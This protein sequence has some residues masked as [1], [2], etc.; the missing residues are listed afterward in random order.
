[1]I[2][3]RGSRDRWYLD[4]ARFSTRIPLAEII[5]RLIKL[6]MASLKQPPV[7]NPDGG[8]NYADWKNDLEVWC[9]LT[10]G[11][12]KQ[13]PAVFL[14]L[15][16]DARDAVRPIP[17]EKLNDKD[18]V[19]QILAELDKVYLKDEVSRAFTAIKTFVQFRRESTQPFAKFLVDFNNKYREVKKHKLD[20]DDGILAFFLLMAANLTE[21]HERLVRATAELKFEDVKDKLQKV[22]G[23][24]DGK[25]GEMHDSKL[26]VKEDC[27]Y[28]RNFNRNG[29]SQSGA[30]S[31]YSQSNQRG[32]F[33]RGTTGRGSF[34]T[35]RGSFSRGAGRT[36]GN[37]KDPQGAVMRCF[38]CEST[39]HMIKDCPHKVKTTEHA[40]YMVQ[41]TFVAGVASREQDV[42]LHE[43]LAR[44]IID[45]GCTKTVAGKAWVDE[46][47]TM[48]NKEDRERVEKSAKK[49][50]TMYRF[51]DG[52][53]TKSIKELAIPMFICGKKIVLAVEVV[54]SNIPLL[55]GRP[56]MT[57]L[58]MI[59]DTV[60]HSVKVDEKTFRLG[61]SSSGHYILPV[62]EFTFE[63]TEFVLKMENLSTYSKAVKKEKAK[64]LHR[65]FAH[66]SKERLFRLL[67]DGGCQDT[68]FFKILEKCCN[69]CKFCQ[70]Y[71]H[72]KP[73]PIVG[74]PKGDRFNQTV[75]MDLKEIHKG[76]LWILHL[77]DN[78]T[79]YT[80]AT[81]I[82]SKRKEVIVKKIFQIWLSYFGSP[83]T[84]HSDCGGEFDNEVFREMS[85]TF[86]VKISTTPG[87]SP[88]SNGI[89][90]RGNTMLY[91]TMMKT[92]EDSKCSMETALAWAV[93]AKNCLQNVNGYSPN[94]LVLGRNVN[95][96]SV[97]HDKL[98][99]LENPTSSDLVR[100]NL[101]TMHKARENFIKS[102]ASERI[103]RALKHNVRTYSEVVF[104]PGEEVYYRGR[105][106]KR[107]K[108]PAKVLGKES[109]FVLIRNGAT[110]YRCH[111]C[112]LIKASNEKVEMSCPQPIEKS[113]TQNLDSSQKQ[114][115]VENESNGSE[116]D[117]DEEEHIDGNQKPIEVENES[118]E[119]EADIDEE[120][121]EINEEKNLSSSPQL[122]EVENEEEDIEINESE[123]LDSSQHCVEVENEEEE[124]ET[125][126]RENPEVSSKSN[127]EPRALRNL[128]NYNKPGVK[129]HGVEFL[130]NS[131]MMP[132]LRTTVQYALPD[133]TVTGAHVLS[134]RTKDK[135]KQVKQV[136]VQVIG[137]ENPSVVDWERVVWWREVGKT[138]QVFTLT[139]IEECE[140]DVVEAKEREVQ[141][142]IE[143]DVFEVVDDKG[144]T[145]VSCRW[146]YQEKQKADGSKLLKAR[147][148]AR[149]FEE[150][151]V[152]KKVDSPTCSRQSLRLALISATAMDW[153]LHVLDISSAFLQG[154]KLKRTVYVKPPP[155]VCEPEKIWRLK[156]CLYG[157]ADAPREWY[158]RVCEEMKKMG[159]TVSIY[160]KSVFMW[161]EDSKLVGLIIT[162][163]D[164][165][166]YCGTLKWQRK[167][168]D[169]LAKTFKISKKEKGC[170]KYIGLNIEQDK[171]QIFIDQAAYVNDLK[172]IS[173]T[174]TR[175]QQVDDSL[176]EEE[177]KKLRSVC[178]QVLWVTSQTRPD[179]AF[180]G[181]II[182]N[183][184]N[185]PKVK[186]LLEANKTVKKLKSDQLKIVYPNLG[187]PTEM[188]VVIY[189]DGSHASLMSGASQGGNI[190]FLTGEG[191]A[192]PVTWK[193]K[194]LDRVTKSPLAT[195]I[196][197][198]AD[199]ADNG[200]LVAAM[201]KE[202]F[203]LQSLPEI[204]LHTDSF[205][206]KE[207]LDSKK[208]I[209]DPRLRVDIARLR[210]M[211][212]MKEVKFKWVP[213]GQQLA[214]CL[215]KK[216]ASTDLLRSVLATGVLPE[217]R[218]SQM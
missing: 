6:E 148:V 129:E 214:D 27:M 159:A 74:F 151:L 44:A 217:H 69:D 95:L 98:P 10:D 169:S 46:F 200:Y 120:N 140:K 209:S 178:G 193:S 76:K 147:L 45:C 14:S 36:R 199:A 172:E 113:G 155:E 184:G 135:G 93:C 197:A 88:F 112:N 47:L 33:G 185:D 180:N 154:N 144:Q 203:C 1:M 81:L 106:D 50:N 7:F 213:S 139:A 156:R 110:Y 160:D 66:A 67:K 210:E 195:E 124:I 162:H 125:N 137:E 54:D 150:K 18:A 138:E 202:L 114:V 3:E 205:S 21:D 99:A 65:Q 12:V 211:N 35:G 123:N 79:R 100:E 136:D 132:S 2:P 60:N 30:G 141:N 146:V 115:E 9:M 145:T 179:S 166:E 84:F 101:N 28:A 103:K 37:P 164:D 167:V 122:V 42:M 127:K 4:T 198:V 57:K 43:A 206:L 117:A 91:E 72:K 51:G 116:T 168:I 58:G 183:Y 171:R 55:L 196:S 29:G 80:A 192:A 108:G 121:I 119:S 111:P 190:V 102:E 177:K 201:A 218:V 176:T 133:G 189:G 38:E 22:F 92:R 105:N 11:K 126:E 71:R 19:K 48:L 163:V 187:E 63:E 82:T 215:T 89:V 68:E 97:A 41:L 161:H 56:S 34:S 73:R 182:S 75:S 188:K 8:D 152:D 181:C 158:D 107:W 96:P 62:S 85:E 87:E 130:N 191:R 153:E 118:S 174:C 23:E 77:V 207:H 15:Q 165:F 13:G 157:L 204:E 128:R 24:F 142:L 86:G 149:G 52:K 90:E 175:K 134:I 143:N 26:P 173:L 94:Q 109:N 49:S 83:E 104:S 170:F 5:I 39:M 64:K 194:R 131:N 25:D 32:N 61:I 216:G 16:G 40:E 59:L 186:C 70:K 208:I 20:F 212:D 31:R 53:E 78:A 17:K